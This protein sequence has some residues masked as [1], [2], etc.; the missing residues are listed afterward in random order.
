MPVAYDED[1]YSWTQEQARFLREGRLELLDLAHLADEVESMG[2]SDGG[3]H[4]RR[5]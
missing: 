2:K 3:A 5:L 1:F 4:V